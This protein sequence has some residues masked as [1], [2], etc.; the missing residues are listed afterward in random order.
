MSRNNA[1]DLPPLSAWQSRLLRLTAFPSPAAQ[2][3][4]PEWWAK[5][6]GTS[7]EIIKSQPQKNEQHM[8]GVWGTGTLELGIQ[9]L[10]ID[11]RYVVIEETPTDRLQALGSIT[12]TLDAFQDLMNRWLEDDT[13]PS[14]FRLAFGAVLIQ[15]VDTHI[16]GYELL[17]R[18]LP[19]D[20]DTKGSSD[21]LYQ[22]NRQRLSTI[23]G[24][25]I[26]RLSRWAVAL[27]KQAAV[28]S[29]SPGVHEFPD[30]FAAQLEVD[31]NTVPE[32]ERELARD[33]LP[34]L[35]N[36]LVE[37]AVEIASEGDIP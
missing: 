37:L 22:I 26:N 2:I 12:E 9:P 5:T 33:Q 35:L 18:Y 19:F 10:R 32:F 14:L 8:E 16:A 20:L 34:E 15:P 21:F 6:V 1:V 4:G 30:L 36:E 31:I 17:S 24:I 25:K 23:L 3:L 7:P 13:V 11:W 27:L 29:A 28:S